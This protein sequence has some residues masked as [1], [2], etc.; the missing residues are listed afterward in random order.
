MPAL[1]DIPIRLLDT[2]MEKEFKVWLHSLPVEKSIKQ[3]LRFL[4]NRA[5]ET[6]SVSEHFE[7]M[8]LT[9]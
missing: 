7:N 3:E 4:W 1:D 9:G 5:T 8:D 2:T 6:I